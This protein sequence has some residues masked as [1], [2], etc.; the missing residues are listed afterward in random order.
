MADPIN[1]K[2][3]LR[4]VARIGTISIANGYEFD[5]VVQREDPQRG[6]SAADKLLVVIEGDESSSEPETQ[7]SA[8]W[9]KPFSVVC[10]AVEDD[11]SATN[12]KT[13]ANQMA[14]DVY[15]AVMIDEFWDDGSGIVNL[16]LNTF[17]RP[18]IQVSPDSG[19]I[20]AVMANFDVMYRTSETNPYNAP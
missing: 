7:G 5:A 16:A 15:R 6:N 19:G 10:Y 12:L 13:R 1:E 17:I 4:V 11:G 14:A 3:A 18:P 9:N 20:Y 8:T 2:I